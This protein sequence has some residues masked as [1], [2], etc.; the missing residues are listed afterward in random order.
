MALTTYEICA[1]ISVV[2]FAVVCGFAANFLFRAARV[3]KAVRQLVLHVDENVKRTE[4]TFELVDG[5]SK[6]LNN[7]WVK[8][9]AAGY[10][11][12]KKKKKID[13]ED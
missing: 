13:C 4:S 9:F 2:F 12:M 10:S 7:S 1:L 6:V 5:V 11:M 3:A 8:V